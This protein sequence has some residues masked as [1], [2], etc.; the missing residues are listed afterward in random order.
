M[1]TT[2]IHPANI[3]SR[4]LANL[5]YPFFHRKSSDLRPGYANV[6][7]SSLAGVS[8]VFISCSFPAALLYLS[9]QV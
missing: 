6:G 3:V 5:P 9:G 4:I 2:Q 1:Q 7:A 8:F